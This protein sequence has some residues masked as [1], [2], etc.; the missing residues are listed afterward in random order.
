MQKAYIKDKVAVTVCR[1]DPFS[2]FNPEYAA[3]FIE[4]PEEVEAGWIV[5][6]EGKW[7]APP[8]VVI[9]PQEITPLQGLLALD[10]FGFSAAFE[11]WESDPARTFAE[12]AFIARAQTWRRNDPTLLAAASAFNLTPKQLDTL[13]I[14]GA[15]L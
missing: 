4:V 13:F 15:Q 5:D 7:S 11:A 1:V 9:V 12:R 3:L 2:I 10:K 8:V 6:D 14:E